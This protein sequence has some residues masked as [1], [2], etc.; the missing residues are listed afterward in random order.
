[1]LGASAGRVLDAALVLSAI[2]A[3]TSFVVL[4]LLRAAL[5][6]TTDIEA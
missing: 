4:A 3:T 6:R 2:L 1:M 5:H